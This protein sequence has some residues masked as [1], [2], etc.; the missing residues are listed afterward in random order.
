MFDKLKDFSYDVIIPAQGEF[1]S[2]IPAGDGKV[3]NLFFTVYAFLMRNRIQECQI[4]ADLEHWKIRSTARSST[5][6]K[7]AANFVQKHYRT[8]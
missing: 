1:G 6:E 8:R 5:F 4:N 3:A 7:R 2:D